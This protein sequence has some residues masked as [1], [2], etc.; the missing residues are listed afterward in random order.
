MKTV[1]KMFARL[2]SVTR[3]D[4]APWPDDDR[5][6]GVVGRCGLVSIGESQR[7]YPDMKLAD[8]AFMA[9]KED[10]CWRGC[11]PDAF[12][13]TSYGV[14]ETTR[15]G[16]VMKTANS[17]YDFSMLRGREVDEYMEAWSF[18]R[19]EFERKWRDMDEEDANVWRYI[20]ADL[21]EARR[22]DQR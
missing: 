14:F 20:P 13:R 1:L 11:A 5:R 2:E 10:G 22:Q 7:L 4:G 17:L 3:A 6:L 16:L 8:F 19:E 9:W 21:E 18:E 12:W 15:S